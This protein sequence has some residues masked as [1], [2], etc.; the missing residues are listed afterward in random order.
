MLFLWKATVFDLDPAELRAQC[1]TPLKTQTVSLS[2]L[3]TE[4]SPS[5]SADAQTS[6]WASD[7]GLWGITLTVRPVFGNRTS[8]SCAM[9]VVRRAGPCRNKDFPTG[10]RTLS[11]LHIRAKVWNALC[12]LGLTQQGLSPPPIFAW[13]PAGLRRIPSPGFTSWM[14]SP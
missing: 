13:Q 2:A 10:L 4:S 9:V 14:F 11:W 3:S 12:T 5:R 6:V 1:S 8:F 7:S